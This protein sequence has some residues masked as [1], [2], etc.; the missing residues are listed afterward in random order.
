M[1]YLMVKNHA[2]ENGNKRLACMSLMFFYEINDRELKITDI[3]MYNLSKKVAVSDATKFESC[4]NDI[5]FYLRSK[6]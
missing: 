6:R 5:K 2:L 1:F 4:V 3:E